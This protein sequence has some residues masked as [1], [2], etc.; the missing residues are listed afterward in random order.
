MEIDLKDNCL[1]KDERIDERNLIKC[2][3]LNLCHSS[4]SDLNTVYLTELR[5]LILMCS[6]IR[7]LNTYPLVNI[8]W[9]DAAD[10]RLEILDTSNLKAIRY[11][12]VCGT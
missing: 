4:L 2:V 7:S 8:I 3:E 5:V 6:R 11:L 10:T 12:S 9:L 1:S